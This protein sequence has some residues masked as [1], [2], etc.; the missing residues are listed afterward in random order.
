MA[1]GI[2]W[3]GR[4][5]VLGVELANEA[6][7]L[8]R[9]YRSGGGLPWDESLKDLWNTMLWP[10]VLLFVGRYTTLF[11]HRSRHPERAS[12]PADR[13]ITLLRNHRP[14]PGM[15]AF[16]SEAGLDGTATLYQFAHSPPPAWPPVSFARSRAN[17]APR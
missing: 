2:N 3:E 11:E 15:P 10:T 17:P 1:I 5:C 7:D 16:R 13:F 4:R 14:K 12:K 6:Y 8:F 9:A